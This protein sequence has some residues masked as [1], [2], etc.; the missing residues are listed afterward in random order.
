MVWWLY[1]KGLEEGLTFERIPPPALFLSKLSE[2]NF[3]RYPLKLFLA[4]PIGGKMNQ[5]T[6]FRRGVLSYNKILL[7]KANPEQIGAEAVPTE[8]WGFF[9]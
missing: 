3:L 9:L 5:A 4:L 1:T 2:I 7:P 8:G 6:C